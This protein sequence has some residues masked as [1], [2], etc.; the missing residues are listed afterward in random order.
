MEFYERV[1]GARMHTAYIRPGGVAKDIPIGL[2][3]D[4]HNFIKTFGSR[5][6]EIEELLTSNRI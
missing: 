2:L 4:I 3:V 1:S 6:N 5:I